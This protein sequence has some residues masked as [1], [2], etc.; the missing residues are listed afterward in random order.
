MEAKRTDGQLSQM[1]DRLRTIPC[2][3]IDDWM[4]TPMSHNELMFIR[5]IMDYRPRSGGTILVSHTHPDRWRE[6]MDGSTSYRDS[7]LHTLTDGATV[8]EL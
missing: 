4:N 1:L 5:E 2:L 7:L 3:V 8:I 6:L